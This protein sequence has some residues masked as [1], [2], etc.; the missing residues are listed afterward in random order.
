MKKITADEL[1]TILELHKKW[2]AK[3]TDGVR[4]DLHKADLSGADLSRADL[5]WADLSGASLNEADLRWADL[6]KADLRWADLRKADLRWADPSEADL[7]GADLRKADLSRADLRWADLSGASLSEADLHWADL[8]GASLSEAV[9]HWADLSGASLRMTNLHWA[10]LSRA[11]LSRADLS[12]ADLSRADLCEVKG[13]PPICCPE[14]GSFIGFKKCS[15]LLG[16][17]IVELEI[18]E[19]ALRSS[20]TTRKCR[21]S[22]AKVLSITNLDGS[23]YNENHAFSAHD[24]S[25]EYVIGKTVEVNEFNTYRWNECSSGIH[26][27]ITRAEAVNYMG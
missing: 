20:A 22:K 24:P 8:S 21:C 17:C 9:L 12:G 2:L 25:F 5:R 23:P 6:H 1:K 18:A 27:F 26:F 14:K 4:A 11:D 10:D 13:L 15:G 16:D 7:S 19:D 3:Q